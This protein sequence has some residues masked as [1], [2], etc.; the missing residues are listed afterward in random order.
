MLTLI[1]NCKQM[2]IELVTVCLRV[3]LVQPSSMEEVRVNISLYN[4]QKL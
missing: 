1:E 2:E 4:F 3:S